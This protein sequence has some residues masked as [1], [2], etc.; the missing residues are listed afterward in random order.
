MTSLSRVIYDNN[1]IMILSGI[2]GILKSIFLFFTITKSI[3]T[4]NHNNKDMYMLIYAYM[5]V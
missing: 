4:Y 2:V 1:N 5:C 3:F